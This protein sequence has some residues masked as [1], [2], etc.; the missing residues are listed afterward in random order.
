M[1]DK[2][3]YNAIDQ[4]LTILEN[5]FR[6]SF[7]KK[8]PFEDIFDMMKDLYALFC[9]FEKNTKNAVKQ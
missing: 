7:G 3:I 1:N 9:N 2:E 8:I 5:N 6:Y 4:T